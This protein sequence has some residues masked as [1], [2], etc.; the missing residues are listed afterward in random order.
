[1]AC[2]VWVMQTTTDTRQVL[3]ALAVHPDLQHAVRVQAATEGISVSEFVRRAIKERL[4][5]ISDNNTQTK[6]EP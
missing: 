5:R 1:M 3:I 4:D 2:I 6:G